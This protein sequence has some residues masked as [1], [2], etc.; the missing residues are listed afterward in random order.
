MLEKLVGV[1]IID[2]WIP[3]VDARW[4]ILPCNT[5]PE[6]ETKLP[7]GEAQLGD[8]TGLYF[9]SAIVGLLWSGNP[10]R[11]NHLFARKFAN[12]CIT[13][14][15]DLAYCQKQYQHLDGC[16][17]KCELQANAEILKRLSSN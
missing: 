1:Q 12:I 2:V 3:T 17:L 8:L 9:H 10:L 6:A 15:N 16:I 4:L 5:Q 7:P 13:L 11:T 14:R